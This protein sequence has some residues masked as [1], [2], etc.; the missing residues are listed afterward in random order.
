MTNKFQKELVAYSVQKVGDGWRWRVYG[1]GGVVVL[2]GI[3]TTQRAA[4]RR[5]SDAFWRQA[6]HRIAA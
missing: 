2:Q 5:S 1:P 6:D 4:D 3:E